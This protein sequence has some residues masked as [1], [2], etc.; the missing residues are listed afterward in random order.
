MD[1]VIDQPETDIRA[2]QYIH[3]AQEISLIVYG[4]PST[5][6]RFDSAYRRRPFFSLHHLEHIYE[7]V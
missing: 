5:Y 4:Q 6:R 7:E 3:I 2:L 1:E